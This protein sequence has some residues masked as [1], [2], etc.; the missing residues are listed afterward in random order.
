[1]SK[2]LE[3]AVDPFETLETY[4]DATRW[5]MISNANLDN[6]KFDVEGIAKFDA[7]FLEPL[8]HLFLF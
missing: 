1:M 7:S 6:L 8:Q 5:Y 2:R 4:G 3:N